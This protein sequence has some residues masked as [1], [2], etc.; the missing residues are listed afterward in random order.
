MLWEGGGEGQSVAD[1]NGNNGTLWR[2][3][4]L[5]GIYM[6]LERL[7]G[8]GQYCDQPIWVVVEVLVRLFF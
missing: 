7:G 8:G 2:D 1:R 6:T 3:E 5:R 4:R